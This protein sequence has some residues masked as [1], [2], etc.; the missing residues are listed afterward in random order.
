[1]TTGA[2]PLALVVPA[3]FPPGDEWKRLTLASPPASI[4]IVNPDSGPGLAGDPAY[5]TTIAAS[6]DAGICVLGYVHTEW[7]ARDLEAVCDDIDCYVAWYPISGIFLDQASINPRDL[8]YYA[9]IRQHLQAKDVR[10]SLM[11]NPGE[12]TDEGYL[13][14]ADIIVTFEETY[15]AYTTAYRPGSWE[16][17]HPPDRFCHLIHTT[18]TQRDMRHAIA[19][20]RARGVGNIYVTSA[21]LPNPWDRLPGRTYWASE[22]SVAQTA[23]ED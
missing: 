2:H 20:G 21:A 16:M 17:R 22:Q 13:S 10:A 1:M 4:A 8:P 18:R 6:Q 14:V 19:L 11:L 23:P 9:A 5:V 3:Y 7:A 15:D 12:A